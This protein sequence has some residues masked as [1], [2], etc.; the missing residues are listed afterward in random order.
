MAIGQKGLLVDTQGNWGNILTGDGAAAGRY[1]EARLSEFALDV[2][3]DNKVTDWTW[4]YDGTNQ[5]PITL[6]AKF[7]LLLAQGAEGIAVGLSCKILPHNFN[8]IID[9]A[10]AY[11]R[12]EEFHLY[13][14]FPTGGYIDV[15]NYKDG[16]RGGNVRVRTKIEKVDNKI[17][18]VK[19]VPYGKTTATVIESILKAAE[20][21]KIKIKK[22]EDNTA[23]TA[24]IIVTLQP[25]TSSD[26][27]IDAL[28]AFS[29]CEISISPCCCVIKDEKP[30]FLNVSELLRFSVNRTKDILKA[31][32][33]YQ[34]KDAL[35]SLLYASLEKI[36][37]EERIYKDRAYEQAKDLDTALAHIDKRLEPYK[38]QFVRLITRDDLLRLLEIKMARILKFNIDK[39][40]N[41]IAMLNERIA[42]IDQ[43]LAHL[44]DYAIEWYE[45]LKKK[46]GSAYPRRTIIRD[47]DTIVAS[48]V[49][50]ANE[51]LYINRADGFI[52]TGLKKDEFVCNCSDI[53]DII[54]FYKD[55]KF[56]VIK[57]SEKIYVGKNI[58]YLNVFKRNDTRTIYNVL[59]QDG[60]GGIVYMK[61]FAVTGVTRDREY[62]L[63]QGKP[64]SKIMWFTANPN[65]EAEVLRITLKPKPRLKVL[66][67][68]IDLA[69]L[70]IKGKLT[71]GNLVTKNEVHRI[72]LKEHGVSTLGDR[73]VWFDPDVLRINY[74]NHGYSLG[75]FSGDDRI[76]VIMKNGDFYTTT[77]EAT[78]HYEDGILRI[79]KY[80]ESKVWTAIVDDADQGYL[81]IKRC[82]LDDRNSKQSMIGGN[83]A[84]KLLALSD[85][86][87]PR[88]EVKFGGGDAFRENL[89]I[90][91]DEFIGVKS[92]KAKGKRVSN[93][94][95]DAIT[96]IEPREVPEEETVAET[97]IAE[98]EDADT[99]VV[100]NSKEIN[101]QEVRDQ[102]TGQTRLFDDDE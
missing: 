21:G 52:G 65:G 23:S 27:A 77:S 85:A 45:R 102:L 30:Q 40:N 43:K 10:V 32:L 31:D 76:L 35:E 5:E 36:F 96:E 93:F 48:K 83:P 24:E 51:K 39:A 13:P 84:S 74:E 92:F 12:G 29:D 1:I 15:N 64:G 63:T 38:S 71:R 22:V 20:K 28:Y 37:I 57:V 88:F 62:D 41:Y 19:D 59:Y 86:K 4:S 87:F 97:A 8:E 14:D 55:G 34:R 91:A 81:Y 6:P 26:K 75:K 53:D 61:R 100:N 82:T 9:A 78:N 25:G 99:T 60:K 56:K 95:I 2:V 94:A 33:E 44:V 42:D 18:L 47:F 46:Y 68:D 73:E 89:V 72:T 54:I 17:L 7:P 50:E 49:A 3:F 16:E 80:A 66:Q 70:G 98:M 101:Q 79:E 11:L 69:D 67:F 90:D 58:I